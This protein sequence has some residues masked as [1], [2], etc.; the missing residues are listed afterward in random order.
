MKEGIIGVEADCYLGIDICLNCSD[1]MCISDISN[2]A[3]LNRWMVKETRIK[4]TVMLKYM[5][6]SFQEIGDMLDVHWKTAQD[7]W[8][9]RVRLN[10]D[11]AFYSNL[12]IELKSYRRSLTK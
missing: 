3:N 8:T 7:Y 11:F 12:G 4:L 10:G 5:G 6:F 2:S 1:D 9:K